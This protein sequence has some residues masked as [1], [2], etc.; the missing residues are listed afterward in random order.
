MGGLVV[1][2]LLI[3]VAVCAPLLT[4]LNGYPPN[5]YNPSTVDAALGGAPRGPLGGV[6]GKHWLGVEPKSG[7]DIFS[8][9]MWGARVSLL[10]ALGATAVAVTLGTTFGVIAGYT[11]GWVDALIGR[12]MDVMLSFPSLIFMIALVSVLPDANRRLLLIVSIGFFGWAYVGRIVRGQTISLARREFVEAARSLGAPR[13]H[14]LVKEL[15]PNLAGPVLVVAT[16]AIPT[17]IAT[18]A[19]LSFLGVGV[20]PPTASWG[21]MLSSAVTW[22]T[23]DPLYFLVPGVCLFVTVMSFNLFGDGL[24]DAIEP[25]GDGS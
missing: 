23:V 14:I 13:R 15:L 10:I 18:E 24:R 11:G 8:R 22:Y 4:W 19:A 2:V 1:M 5:Q 3:L 17:Y 25:R 21:Q 12:A 20:R 16:L 9:A 7:R 6:S